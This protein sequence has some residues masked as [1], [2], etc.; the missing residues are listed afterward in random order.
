MFTVPPWALGTA[1]LLLGMLLFVLQTR[2]TEGTKEQADEAAG[3]NA[4][5]SLLAIVST[6]AGIW[7]L[8]I[9]PFPE[10]A[11]AW[12][13]AAG[14]GTIGALTT[15]CWPRRRPEGV[16]VIIGMAIQATTLIIR[17]TLPGF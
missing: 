3:M 17:A 6:G 1:L 9:S 5:L 12:T 10:P 15:I 13:G 8:W 7:T 2:M 4:L 16:A 14:V 11:S